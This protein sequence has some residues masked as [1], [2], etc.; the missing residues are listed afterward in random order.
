MNAPLAMPAAPLVDH[1]WVAQAQF[2]SDGV[3]LALSADGWLALRR[4]GRVAMLEEIR[5]TCDPWQR[6]RV[7]RLLDA[8]ATLAPKAIDALLQSPR[9]ERIEVLSER[10]R[11]GVWTLDLRLQAE[12]VPFDDH[13]AQAPVIPGVLQVG[14]AIALAAPR[15]GTPVHCREM[16]ALKFQHLLRPG[17]RLVLTLRLDAVSGQLHFAYHLDGKHCSSGRLHVGGAHD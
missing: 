7:C 1:P 10:E 15:L 3:L 16:H 12:L 14:W 4:L 8:P 9:P 5:M 13:F 11:D 2:G 17:D 6:W